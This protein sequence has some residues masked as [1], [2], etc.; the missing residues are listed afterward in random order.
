MSNTEKKRTTPKRLGYRRRRRVRRRKEE[1]SNSR[2]R[3]RAW[4]R[5]PSCCSHHWCL[6]SLLLLTL[7]ALCARDLWRWMWQCPPYAFQKI[8]S[9]PLLLRYAFSLINEIYLFS[10]FQ[11]FLSHVPLGSLRSPLP[12]VSHPFFAML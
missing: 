5:I 12:S 2:N 4:N 7:D 6:L 8:C 3:Y 9:L 1:E 11:C 10:Y